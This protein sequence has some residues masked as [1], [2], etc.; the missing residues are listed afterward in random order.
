MPSL[1]ERD[2]RAVLDVVGETHDAQD[3]DE[4]RAV[5]LPG[6]RRL[7][8]TDYSSY[9]EVLADG[10][11]L[12]TL[13]QPEVPASAVAAWERYAGDNPLVQHF[14]RT[15][16]GRAYRFSDVVVPGRFRRTA[17]FQEL[18]RPL[19]IDHQLAFA[20][21]SAPGLT[22]GIALSRGG[23]NF[24]ERDRQVLNLTRPHLIQAYRN[25]ELRERLGGI[26]EGMRTGL[27]AEGT[28][29]IVLDGEGAVTFASTRARALVDDFAERPLQD[30]LPPP[31]PLD[32]WTGGSAATASLPLPGRDDALLVRRLRA[33]RSARAI[34]LDRA[35]RALSQEGLRGLGL[36]PREA[37]V[38][39]G[40]ARGIAP[41]ALAAELGITPRTVAKHV[42]RVHAKLG[43]HTRAQ[44]VAAAWAAAG[45]P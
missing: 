2:L 21:P 10:R 30:G 33:G 27:D 15:R 44:A 45:G 23:R 42:Q 14:A 5:L 29:L 40:L 20:L 35:A 12:A 36:T 34:V 31:P 39:H 24:S 41:V 11:T 26:V 32:A 9:N 13:A 28:A 3:R 22:I 37:A 19:G 4:F 8:E 6:I 7:V 1:G 18:Y 16:D 25:S 38:L 17:I 43:V